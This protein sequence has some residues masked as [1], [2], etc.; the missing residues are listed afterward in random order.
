MLF[1]RSLVLQQVVL[2][3]QPSSWTLSGRLRRRMPIVISKVSATPGPVIAHFSS[4]G[5]ADKATAGMF[6][7]AIWS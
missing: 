5:L 1:S 7:G 3:A 6:S 2:R 4:S